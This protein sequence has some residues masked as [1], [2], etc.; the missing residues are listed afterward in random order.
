M[1]SPFGFGQL[2]V[3]GSSPTGAGAAVEEAGELGRHGGV[4]PDDLG[5]VHDGV[6]AEAGHGDQVV[7]GVPLGVPEPGGAVAPHPGDE[8]EGHRG[9]EV[10]VPGRAARTAVAL[11]HERRHHRVAGGEALHML[12]H[13]LHNPARGAAL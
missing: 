5:H 8:H 1:L 12:P 6:L 7:E 11:P 10:V 2:L 3:L 4:D 13:A 9:A